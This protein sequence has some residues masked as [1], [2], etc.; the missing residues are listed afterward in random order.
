MA[1]N[2]K[3]DHGSY[4]SRFPQ[5][6]LPRGASLNGDLLTWDGGPYRYR[7]AWAVRNQT[8]SI[9]E[10]YIAARPIAYSNESKRSYLMDQTGIISF[11]YDE[12]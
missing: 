6:G 8:G 4:A 5:L 7:I 9:V 10:Y 11:H 3:K 12:S 1:G 2:Y